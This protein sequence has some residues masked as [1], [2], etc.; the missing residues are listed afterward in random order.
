VAVL[1]VIL[2]P[3]TGDQARAGQPEACFASEP[4]TPL[5]PNP[6][7]YTATVKGGVDAIGDWIVVI[8]RPQKGHKARTITIDSKRLPKSC[9]TLGPRTICPI[10]TIKPHDKVAA[11]ARTAPTF[12]G[13]GNPCPVPNPGLPPPI[14]GGPC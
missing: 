6:C 7:L 2:V 14:L 8:K 4:S 5:T 11:R 1:S 13:T 10:G 3:F 12:V 9:V